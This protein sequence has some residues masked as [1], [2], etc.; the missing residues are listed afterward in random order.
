MTEIDEERAPCQKTKI[1]NDDKDT[2][3]VTHCANIRF[4]SLTVTS[5]QRVLDLVRRLAFRS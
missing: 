3:C 5:H 1:E 2:T 4:Q